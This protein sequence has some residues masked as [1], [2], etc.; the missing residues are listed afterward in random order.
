MAK[1]KHDGPAQSTVDKNYQAEDDA[2]TLT[3]AQE[4]RGD[5]KRHTCAM[6]CLKKQNYAA[7]CALDME[8]KVKKGLAA[9]F[10]K[11]KK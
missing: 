7:K 2:R 6:E 11:E 5:S 4:V 8:A 9:A 10:P 3:R 1:K